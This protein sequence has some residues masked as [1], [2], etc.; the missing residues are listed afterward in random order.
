MPINYTQKGNIQ[1][2]FGI[3]LPTGDYRYQDYF[4]WNDSIK[5]LAPVNASIQLGD[6]GTGIVT[7]LN[8]FYFFD[9]TINFYGNFY[10]LINPREQN[11]VA[12]S[13]GGRPIPVNTVKAGGDQVSVP[14]IYSVRA[15]FNFNVG[16]WAFAAGIRD[17]G[18]PVH[19]L[20]GGSL[21]SR[22][23]GYTL[24]AEPGIIYKFKKVTL[25]T[26][27]PVTVAHAIRQNE[28]D[29]NVSKLTGVYSV[30][31][32]GSGDYQVFVGVQ[33]QL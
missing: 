18:S 13:L 32:G 19:D 20:V 11:G 1:V 9:K 33:F 28:V 30:A 6:G 27:V 23:A 3:K 4:H 5:V 22:R 31:M 25:Y 10:Y 15:G 12:A 16:N 2:G 29:K 8:T 26:Y 7:E 14:D 24:S 21:G 17:E